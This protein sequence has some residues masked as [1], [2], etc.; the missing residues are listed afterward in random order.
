M[1]GNV[2][3]WCWDRHDTIYYQTCQN[4]GTVLNPT[5]PGIGTIVFCEAVAG[6]T[7][8]LV[9]EWLSRNYNNF[10]SLRQSHRFS[11]REII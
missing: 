1:S 2:L 4:Q 8:A 6:S 5:G 9:A 11:S 3:E 7:M 10:Y